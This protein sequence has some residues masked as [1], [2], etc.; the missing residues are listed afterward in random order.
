MKKFLIIILL[1]SISREL[2]VNAQ[3]VPDSDMT[4]HLNFLELATR[5]N[6]SHAF[7][8][9]QLINEIIFGYYFLPLT[10]KYVK[11]QTVITG[12]YTNNDNI[13]VGDIIK[14]INGI[15]IDTL[16]KNLR[17]YTHGSNVAS[18]E[19]NINTRILRGQNLPVQMML[20]NEEGVKEVTLSRDVHINLILQSKI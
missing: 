19:R 9:S 1:I 5:I 2:L 4:Y 18:I 16:R 15:D 8:Y 3:T 7:T 17:K 13:E 20:L 11:N 14:S 12:I 10:L 6:D